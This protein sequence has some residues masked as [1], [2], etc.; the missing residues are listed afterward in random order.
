M[1]KT[2]TE[3]DVRA[4]YVPREAYDDLYEMYQTSCKRT[5][6]PKWNATPKAIEVIDRIRY[7]SEDAT[8]LAFQLNKYGDA[9]IYEGNY[10][11]RSPHGRYFSLRLTC[12]SSRIRPLAWQEA[13]RVYK[14]LSEKSMPYSQAIP[15]P[16]IVDA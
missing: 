14:G 12:S 10:L 9:V 13:G 1:Q 3:H 5:E 2:Y 8:L 4:N 15:Y 16:P 6:P 7:S 11:F